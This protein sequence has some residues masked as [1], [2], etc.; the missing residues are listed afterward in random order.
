MRLPPQ[1][2][3]LSF[4]TVLAFARLGCAQTTGQ[5]RTKLSH[6]ESAVAAYALPRPLRTPKGSPIES[7]A[8]WEAQRRP[9]LLRLFEANEY[10]VPPAGIPPGPHA[11]VIWVEQGALHGKAIRKS[12]GPARPHV[13][14]RGANLC[15]CAS[16]RLDYL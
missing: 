12:H 7:V 3:F 11:R 15:A 10:R 1:S 4:L 2:T 13:W 9:E 16:C 8:A 5:A 14:R 6:D